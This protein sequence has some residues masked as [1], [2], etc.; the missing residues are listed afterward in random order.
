MSYIEKKYKNKIAEVFLGITDLEKKL[1][2]AL[3]KQSLKEADNIG[4]LC[5]DCN[6][7]INTILKKFYPEIVQISDKLE[8]KSRL[9]FYYD[10]IDKLST[11]I[12]AFENFQKVEPAYYEKIVEFIKDKESLIA[13][14]YKA[15]STQELTAFYDPQS[16]ENL[17]RILMQ[18]LTNKEREFFTIGSLEQEIKKIAKVVGATDVKISSISSL[19]KSDREEVKNSMSAPQS[20]VR[21]EVDLDE[22][23]VR[24]LLSRNDLKGLK[25]FDIEMK[26]KLIR[27]YNELK[28]YLESKKHEVVL[29]NPDYNYNEI[30]V[31][32]EIEVVILRELFKQ[33]QDSF[34]SKGNGDEKM[35]EKVVLLSKRMLEN[36]EDW[37]VRY[38]NSIITSVKLLPD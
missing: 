1:I 20:I 32:R 11:L 36:Y 7:Q 31:G 9:M 22:K 15:I 8:I 17:E 38:A 19:E 13:G 23:K 14:K 5:A 37:E 34:E 12:R 18:K 21:F 10:L 3:A 30:L 4:K 6:K 26:D 35:S 2:E 27:I 24:E 33:I 25:E 28:K 16:R 29:M